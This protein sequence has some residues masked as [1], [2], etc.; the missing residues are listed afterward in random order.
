MHGTKEDSQ[1]A[2]SSWLDLCN[3]GDY[4]IPPTGLEFHNTQLLPNSANQQSAT[5]KVAPISPQVPQTSR[6]Q[7]LVDKPR[8]KEMVKCTNNPSNPIG[9]L[10]QS[11]SSAIGSQGNRGHKRPSY[12]DNV[13]N[14]SI[15]YYTGPHYSQLAAAASSNYNRNSRYSYYQQHH[16]T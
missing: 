7:E 10:P 1:K 9:S 14:S 5:I 6:E 16:H 11:N 2:S 12:G 8:Q 13:G 4:N 15:H 3:N